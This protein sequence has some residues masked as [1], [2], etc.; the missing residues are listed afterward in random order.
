M[1]A[2]KVP[3][4][5]TWQK[6]LRLPCS[7]R[8]YVC[9]RLNFR[10]QINRQAREIVFLGEMLRLTD[11]FVEETQISNVFYVLDAWNETQSIE[12]WQNVAQTLFNLDCK[13]K[14]LCGSELLFVL[15]FHPMTG[16]LFV[17]FNCYDRTN[18][19]ELMYLP[20]C[21]CKG[22]GVNSYF[23]QKK[24]FKQFHYA[25][26]L[27]TPKFVNFV[28]FSL[29]VNDFHLI[30]YWNEKRWKMLTSEWLELFWWPICL[31]RSWTQKS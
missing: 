7:F 24:H 20:K 4:N 25:P 8:N 19:S 18:V 5:D 21:G 15:I 2:L 23:S 3:S 27:S 12:P 22:R 13:D 1:L 14:S 26:P 10:C 11:N 6:I 28:N 16:V 30:W 29:F 17:K 9:L 31:L